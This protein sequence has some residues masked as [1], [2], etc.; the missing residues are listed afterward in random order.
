LFGP[1][2]IAV[3][4]D[5]SL[6]VTDTGNNRVLHYTADGEP[7][8]E[9]RGLEFN[10]PVGITIADGEVLVA[11]AWSGRVLRF[12]EASGYS[13]IDARWTSRDVLHKPYVA[14]LTDGRILASHPETGQL[15]LFT[16]T[17]EPAGSWRPLQNSIPV[18][19]VARHDG[20]FAFSDVGMNMIQIVPASLVESLFE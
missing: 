1:R 12:G 15:L 7:L 13:V 4:A 17:G 19:V 18:G 3:A 9:L 11:D 6:W 5:G 16:N 2:D 10:E 8:G 20:G 14:V